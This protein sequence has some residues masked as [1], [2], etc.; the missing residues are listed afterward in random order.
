MS[1]VLLLLQNDTE[2]KQ[3]WQLIDII[4]FCHIFFGV[5]SH[6]ANQPFILGKPALTTLA[7]QWHQYDEFDG[8]VQDCSNSSVSAMELLQSCAKPSNWLPFRCWGQK[9]L[10]R[11]RSILKW[12]MPIAQILESISLMKTRICLTYS[13]YHGCW[14]PGD[15]RSQGINNHDIDIILKEYSHLQHE[16]HKILSSIYLCTP[17]VL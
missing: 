16:R 10:K 4:Y 15:T 13:Q 7:L 9:I 6:K 5:T 3:L 1:I 14:S 17:D 8:L 11:T 12:L 2:C